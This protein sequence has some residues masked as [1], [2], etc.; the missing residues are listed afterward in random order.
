MQQVK[1]SLYFLYRFGSNSIC[2]K[3]AFEVIFLF[4]FQVRQIIYMYM[5]IG[6]F[7]YTN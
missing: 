1:V 6:V 7:S 5:P 3:I 4:I 2:I